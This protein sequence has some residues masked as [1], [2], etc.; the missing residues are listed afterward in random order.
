MMSNV[1]TTWNVNNDQNNAQII[2]RI[3]SA[4]GLWVVTLKGRYINPIDG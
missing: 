2:R 1:I 4:E 3:N